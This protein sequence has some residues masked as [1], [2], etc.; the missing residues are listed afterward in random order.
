MASLHKPR[1]PRK[2]K[3]SFLSGI[4]FIEIE[5]ANRPFLVAER[6]NVIGSKKFRDLITQGQFEEGAEIARKQIKS[7]AS[8]VDVCMSNPDSNELDDMN[9]FLPFLGRKVKAPIMIDST[10]P[11]VMEAALK[12]IQGKAI[13][14]SINL[15]NGEERFE[16]IVPLVHAY[17]ASLVVGTIDEDPHEGMGITAERKLQ[18][19][20]RSYRLLTEKFHISP[21][22]IYFDPLVFPVGTGD[23]KYIQSSQ[24]TLEALREIKKKF[25]GAKT[26]LGVSNIS[27]GLPPAGREVLNSVFLYH[28]VKAGLDTAIVNSE[29]LKR[30]PT[31]SQE[32]RE[33]AENLLFHNRDSYD[34]ALREFSQFY[35]EKKAEK[36]QVRQIEMEPEQRIIESLV[37]GSKEFIIED[38]EKL[39]KDKNLKPLEIINGPLMAGMAEVGKLFNAN[40]LIVAEVLQ[41]AEVM[42]TAVSHLEN[43][44][45]KGEQNNR[46]T[47]ILATVKGDVHDIGKN[48]VE[49]ILSNNG[50]R[51]IDLGIKVGPETLIEAYEKHKPQFIGLSGL[52]VK[53]AQQMVSTAEDLKRHN[54]DIPLLVGGAAL[55]ESFVRTKIAPA[56]DSTSIYAKD[57]MNGLEILNNLSNPETRGKT[58]LFWKSNPESAHEESA[59]V[60][61]SQSTRE[62]KILSYNYGLKAPSDLKI[63]VLPGE[64]TNCSQLFEAAFKYI[65]SGMLYKKHLGFRGS[66]KE[67]MAE[68]QDKYLELEKVV[69]AAQDMLLNDPAFCAS[70]V[71]GFFRAASQNDQVV[72]LSSDGKNELARIP[73]PRQESGERLC[74]SDFLAPL[75][76]GL[77]DYMGLLVTSSGRGIHQKAEELKKAGSFLLSHTL[78]ALALESAEGLAEW[79]HQKM[80]TMWGWPDPKD[81]TLDWLFQ[82]K[83]QGIRLSFGYPACPELAHQKIFWDLLRPD[84]KINVKLTEGFMMDPEA[85]VS[86]L[87]FQHPDGKYFSVK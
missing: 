65:N 13:I 66:L 68:G 10:D 79:L 44:M 86:A 36:S 28:A 34:H 27:F 1:I 49:I 61:K 60:S 8:I 37:E 59:F 57:A 23:E 46:G 70:A 84:E 35:K 21:E 51:I 16:R 20:E 7:G 67:A 9:A 78:Q 82:T 22:D 52:L 41:S 71:Y 17:G 3:K 25:P 53:S 30:Y 42:K 14:N 2:I 12:K 80:R 47:M 40:Q 56:Y 81:W 58:E 83:F 5:E 62:R 48:L 6:T 64:G 73:F 87:V 54:I 55:S 15:E 45:E 77:Q 19:A 33:L 75:H 29:K 69:R 4:D 72:L 24:F 18:I 85:S 32:E 76:S 43:Y 26:I 50:Y 38:L 11:V 39:R 74:A 31:I 63:H